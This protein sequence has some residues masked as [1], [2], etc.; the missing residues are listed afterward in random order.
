MNEVILV[1]ITSSCAEHCMRGFS[2]GFLTSSCTSAD[3]NGFLTSSCTSADFLFQYYF[4][5]SRTSTSSYVEEFNTEYKRVF[6]SVFNPG[7]KYGGEIF[8]CPMHFERTV[9]ALNI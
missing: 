8:H 9:L 5:T 3:S 7:T 1:P 4:C 2:N 6:T